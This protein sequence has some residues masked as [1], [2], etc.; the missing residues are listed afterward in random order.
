MQARL[1]GLLTTFADAPFAGLYRQLG[2]RNCHHG[3]MPPP[4]DWNGAHT[5]D[6]K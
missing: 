4:A 3:A 5:F 2:E 1:Q 6:S